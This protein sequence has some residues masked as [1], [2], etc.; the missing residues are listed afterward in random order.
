MRLAYNGVHFIPAPEGCTGNC[1][2]VSNPVAVMCD[3]VL[4]G[5]LYNLVP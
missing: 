2:Q 4:L 1:Q 3:K 5:W